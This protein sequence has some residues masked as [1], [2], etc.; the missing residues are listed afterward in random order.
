MG[1]PEKKQPEEHKGDAAS[2][3]PMGD[4]NPEAF[5]NPFRESHSLSSPEPCI[6]VIFGASGDLTKRKLIPALF[7]LMKDG[8]LPQN[9]V[10]VG[11][12][13]RNMT[14]EDFRKIMSEGINEF[15]RTRPEGEELK[16]FTNRLF[17]HQSEFG[18]DKGYD[19]LNEA[20]SKLDKQFGT[21]GNRVYYLS[22]QP[23]AFTSIVEKLKMHNLVY[24]EEETER[25]SRVIIEKP[26]GHDLNTANQLQS[27]LTHNL[28]EKQIYRIDHYLGKETVQNLLVFRFSN[29]IFEGLWNNRYIDNVQI[30][31]GE[32]IGV[33]GRGAFYEGAGLVRDIIQNHLMQL[34]S[35]VAM[36]PPTSLNPESIRDEKV[37]VLEAIKHY[38]EDEFDK[39]TCRGQYTEGYVEG[40][41]ATAYRKEK[42]VNPTSNVETFASMRIMIENW[43]WS[44]VPFYIRAGKRLPKRSTEIVITFKR[45]PNILFHKDDKHN[46]PNQIIFRIQPNEGTSFQV[47]S[48]VPGSANIIQ[49]V[50]M[51]FQ[52]ASYFGKEV[53]EAYERL[54]YDCIL[55]DNTLFARVDE[56]LNSWKFLT[57]VLEH[58]AKNPLTADDFYPAGT[59]GPLGA[60]YLLRNEQRTWKPL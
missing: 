55:G 18:D 15:S 9:F 6:L 43:R 2:K 51:D 42:N 23:T 10:C 3:L 59:W 40:E 48:K 32:S 20:L 22:V 24:E 37:K 35:L 13:R 27:D 49:P 41:Q 46:N 1:M 19:S 53:P 33:E 17:Y 14:D 8:L 57:P 21:R 11:F 4:V 52:Y 28:N 47:N 39:Y 45:T 25:F 30:S 29:A 58:W 56:S 7:N 50:N 12:A 36:E 54:I 26:F 34:L 60:D 31:V 44:G 5:K 38:T 16:N